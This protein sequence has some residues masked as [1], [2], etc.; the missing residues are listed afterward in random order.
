MLE[1]A[2][3]TDEGASRVTEIKKI[4]RAVCNDE[5]LSFWRHKGFWNG[6]YGYGVQGM[7]ILICLIRPYGG[8]GWIR[9]L[10][11]TVYRAC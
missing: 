11:T 9:I 8:N 10:A 7:L 6:P 5:H 1:N 4:L 3:N 2:I